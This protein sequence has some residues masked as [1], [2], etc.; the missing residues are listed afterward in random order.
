[1]VFDYHTVISQLNYTVLNQQKRIS[2]LEKLVEELKNNV[3]EMNHQTPV[4]IDRIDYHFDQLK[5]ERLEGTLNIGINPNDAQNMD[6]FS[7]NGDHPIQFEHLLRNNQQLFH[8][9]EQSLYQYVGTEL[10]NLIDETRTKLH[11]TL[12]ES[13]IPVIQQ[14]IV[15]Q[16]P[17]RVQYYFNKHQKELNHMNDHEKQLFVLNHI[18]KDIE[19]AVY[20]FIEQNKKEGGKTDCDFTSN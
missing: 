19:Q 10:P 2:K 16:I 6:E 14:D 7:V 17:N 8:E 5:I 9:V 11:S 20:T 18:K 4:H 15:K 1:L 12:D 13:H 3:D